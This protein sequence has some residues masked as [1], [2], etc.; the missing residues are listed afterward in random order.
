MF[1]LKFFDNDCKNQNF[2]LV[3]SKNEIKSS[4]KLNLLTEYKILSKFLDLDTTNLT[5]LKIGLNRKIQVLSKYNTYDE[6]VFKDY[7]DYLQKNRALKEATY[8][9]SIINNIL[10]KRSEKYS[11]PV[12]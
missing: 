8:T 1:E 3:D 12:V 4:F 9:L 10:L 11:V 2:I 5:H 6:N 7:Y